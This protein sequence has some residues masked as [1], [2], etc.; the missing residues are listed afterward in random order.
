MVRLHNEWDQLPFT[1]LLKSKTCFLDNVIQFSSVQSLSRVRLFATPWIAARQASLSITNSRSSLR[2]T[3][4]K[5][6][7]PSSHLILCRPLLLLPPI[8]IFTANS[9]LPVLLSRI[10]E[11][12]TIF[13]KREKQRT[14]RMFS[15]LSAWDVPNL[16]KAVP[17]LRLLQLMASGSQTCQGLLYWLEWCL[18]GPQGQLLMISRMPGEE[19]LATFLLGA[20]SADELYPRCWLA[21]HWAWI[22]NW[23]T[24][25]RSFSLPSSPGVLIPSHEKVIDANMKL[26]GGV[27]RQYQTV[28]KEEN[29]SNIKN[30]VLSSCMLSH[31]SDVWLFETPWIVAW[32]ALLSM[33]FSRQGYWSGFPC[34]PP[35]DL[36]HPGLK[37]PSF[38]SHVLQVDSPPLSHLGSPLSSCH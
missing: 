31:F 38:I 12:S 13:L 25:V 3:S 35:G 36:P 6:V 30:I 19:N 16:P 18:L 1:F 34:H 27:G 23:S 14:K 7:M 17:A 21:P 26:G 32:Q 15:Y 10:L 9:S 29:N 33:G 28:N 37:P 8:P 2:L 22:C 4:I 24:W 11:N 5:S 20:A